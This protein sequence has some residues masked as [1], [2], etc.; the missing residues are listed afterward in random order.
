MV[1]AVKMDHKGRLVIPQS[2]REAL[3]AK[4]GDVFYLVREGKELRYVKGANP[5]DGLAEHAISEH[6]AGKTRNLR[7]IAKERGSRVDE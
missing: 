6:R 7:T 2:D 1:T 4:P 3:G 5:F